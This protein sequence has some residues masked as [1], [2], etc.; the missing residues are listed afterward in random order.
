ME[1]Y[2]QRVIDEKRE[3]D[4]KI[5]KLDTFI[6]GEVYIQLSLMERRRLDQQLFLM[7][8]LSSVLGERIKAFTALGE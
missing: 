8:Q 4:Q 5:E 2:Q 6:K 3:L 1:P 7:G